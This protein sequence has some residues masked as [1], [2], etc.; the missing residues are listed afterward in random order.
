MGQYAEDI[1]DGNCDWQ[2]DYTK[3]SYN[4]AQNNYT[5]KATNAE[6]CIKKIRK[7]LAM[8]IENYQLNNVQNPVNTARKH[9]NTKYGTGWRER[10]LTSNGEQWKPLNEYK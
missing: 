1:I 4:K 7:E 3:S 8:L 2:G 5:R 9:I 6:N 10:G